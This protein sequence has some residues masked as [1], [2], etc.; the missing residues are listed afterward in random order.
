MPQMKSTKLV[1]QIFR[2]AVNMY[3][4]CQ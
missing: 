2:L 3:V 4:S 1:N